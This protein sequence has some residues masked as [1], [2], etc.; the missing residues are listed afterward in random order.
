MP[1][2]YVTSTEFLASPYGT[3]FA[4][5][6]S[7]F[8]SSGEI[9]SF[10]AAMSDI[11]DLYCNRTFGVQTY[12]EVYDN[13]N[14]HALFL[15]NFPVVKINS[16]TWQTVGSASSG[17]IDPSLYAVLQTGKIKFFQ[18]INSIFSGG[19]NN[20]Y[21]SNYL[22][23]Y[24]IFTINYNAGYAVVPGPI[25]TATMMLANVYANAIDNNAVA[26]A[27][28]GASTS[29]KFSKFMESY[30]DPKHRDVFY[31]QGIPVTVQAILRRY[32]A[33]I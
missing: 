31:N 2:Q 7:L 23:N 5:G 21:S 28:G 22:N 12:A 4:I 1:S 18:N 26:F 10:L 11:V 19:Y 27:D 9:D 25:K 3:D 8:T 30:A 15:R 16:I 32:Q 33:M 29:F 24:R 17:V 13:I 20:I 6:N 14:D